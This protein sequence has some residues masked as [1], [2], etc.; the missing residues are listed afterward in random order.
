MWIHE[1]FT[2]YSENIF[3]EYYY[4][5]E[6]GADYVIGTRARIR[7]KIPIIGTYNVNAE[8]SS[9]MYLKEQT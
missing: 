5:T 1:S 8:G 3:V 6:A 4:G 2:T 7:N 9:D